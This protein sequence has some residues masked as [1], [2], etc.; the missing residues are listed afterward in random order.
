MKILK[1]VFLG[2]VMENGKRLKGR[3][4]KRNLSDGV[5]KGWRMCRFEVVDSER[6][7]KKGNGFRVSGVCLASEFFNVAKYCERSKLVELH[8][9][10]SKKIA[11]GEISS[12][13]I[14][15]LFEGV[16]ETRNVVLKWR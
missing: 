2:K 6:N 4:R 5:K 7:R 11:D 1:G 12:I 16:I 10:R 8:K 15:R 3:N 9:G 14:R 13:N